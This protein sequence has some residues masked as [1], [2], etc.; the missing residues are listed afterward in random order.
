MWMIQ[1]PRRGVCLPDHLPHEFIL[2]HA[3]PYLGRFVSKPVD[4]TPL[5]SW[6]GA[7]ADYGQPKPPPQDVWQFNTFLVRMG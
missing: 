5:K 2:K 7:F 4:W 6:H 1:N 3:K